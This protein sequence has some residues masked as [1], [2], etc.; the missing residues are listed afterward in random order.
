VQ[1]EGGVDRRICEHACLDHARSTARTL[2]GRLEHQLDR[3]REACPAVEQ[4]SGSAEKH[5]R[6]RVV[7]AG[8]HDPGDLRGK[9]DTRPLVDW[10][11]VHVCSQQQAPAVPQVTLDRGNHA[12]LRESR[13]ERD[14]EFLKPSPDQA[15]GLFFLISQFGMGVDAPSIFGDLRFDSAG[16]T[17]QVGADHGETIA[18]H[19]K[20]SANAVLRD[21][22]SCW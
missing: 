8:V 15:R 18:P 13:E 9:S 21:H 2:L 10:E 4:E 5:R 20:G 1:S 16:R 12:G 14:A 17:Q 3:A 11:G 7:P 6:V 22:A 19:L